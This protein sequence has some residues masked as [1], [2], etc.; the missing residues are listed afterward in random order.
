[1]F[2]NS[3]ATLSLLMCVL[4]STYIRRSHTGAAI[5]A[6]FPEFNL[7]ATFFLLCGDVSYLKAAKQTAEKGSLEAMK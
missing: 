1:M 2:G 5:E 7:N 3:N 6:A 4:P